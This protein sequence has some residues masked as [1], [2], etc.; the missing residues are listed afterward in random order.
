[1]VSEEGVVRAV[2]TQTV[3]V[4]NYNRAETDFNINQTLLFSGGVGKVGY[5]RQLTPVT[6]NVQIVVRFNRDTL[7][8]YAVFDLNCPVTIELPPNGGRYLSLYIVDNDQYSV[9]LLHSTETKSASITISYPKADKTKCPKN[10]HDDSREKGHSKPKKATSETRYVYAIFR[11]FVDPFNP[12]DVLEANRLQDAIKIS[13]AAVGEWSWPYW[14]YTTLVKVRNTVAA[15]SPLLE[16]FTQVNGYR[17]K[18]DP[19]I[20]LIGT[21]S[22]WGGNPPEEAVYYIIFPPALTDLNQVYYIDIPSPS[23]IPINSP[24]F[25]SVTVYNA[26]GFLQYNAAASYSVNGVTAQ[27]ES[28]GSIRIYFSNTRGADMKNWLYIYQG[29]NYAIRLY[30]PQSAILNNEWTFPALQQL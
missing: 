7:Y 23:S 12:A 17:N 13:Q 16:P 22:L 19:T 25:W 20:H 29:W 15:L 8:G 26:N 6:S 3:Y 21:A 27:T 24:G 11:V 30:L 14:N 1:M 5:L 18:I 10:T 9:A 28:D 2:T 4:Q